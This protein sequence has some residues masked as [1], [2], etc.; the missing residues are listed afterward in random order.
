MIG[1]G[2]VVLKD[3]PPYTLAGRVPV[4][5][6]GLNIVGLKRR[7]FTED[8]IQTID[9]FYRI[10]YRSGMNVSDALAF[11]ESANPQPVPNIAACIEFIRSSK[12][13]IVRMPN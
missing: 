11:Y 1:G 5:V 2:S 6:E 12:R 8:D 9:A 3:V 7:G 10:L 13:G 4:V